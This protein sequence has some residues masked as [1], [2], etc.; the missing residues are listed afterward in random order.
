[1]ETTSESEDAP[2]LHGIRVLD[3]T[4]ILSGPYC[5]LLLG[6]LGAEVIKVERSDRGDD[7]R[8]WGPPFLPGE[9]RTSA[10][11]AALNRGK[12]SVAVDFRS[13]EAPRLVRDLAAV[14]DVVVENF[15]PGVAEKIG[16][17]YPPLRAANAGVVLCSISAFDAE[18]AYRA[19]PG[20]EIV[21][22]ALSGLMAITGSP[23]GAPARFGIAMTDIATGLTAAAKVLAALVVTKT[24]GSGR[25]VRASL[26]GTAQAAL[27]TL[28]SSYSL[29]GEEPQRWGSHHPS[30][31]PYGAFPSADGY[32]VMGVLNDATW[33]SFCDALGLHHLVADE[34]LATNAGRV[35]ERVAVHDAIEAA[36][37]LHPTR[38]WV[39][40]LRQRDLLA[41]PVRGLGDALRDPD[42][43]AFEHMVRLD[44]ADGLISP[45]LDGAAAGAETQPVPRLG[46]H[47]REVL[48]SILGLGSEAITTLIERGVVTADRPM[49]GALTQ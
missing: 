23:D 36:T 13:A 28:I 10:Y 1:M 27:A 17:A 32:V 24:T 25:H 40:R 20:T 21:V 46:Q 26:Y 11:F 41:A 30:I 14:S 18:G 3:L 12:K 42:M 45:R 2:P 35:A 6:D 19:V 38:Y 31:V 33:P 5:T 43:R 48:S 15:R 22:E 49:E 4:R 34:S 44:G 47:T 7:T 29:T 8:D 39:E 37:V 16:L 9:V